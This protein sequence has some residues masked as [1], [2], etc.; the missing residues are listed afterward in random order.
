MAYT[1]ATVSRDLCIAISRCV[2]TLLLVCGD[3]AYIAKDR[4]IPRTGCGRHVASGGMTDV[5][6]P[7]ERL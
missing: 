1:Q 3:M 4:G 2:W 6:S 5:E 7:E